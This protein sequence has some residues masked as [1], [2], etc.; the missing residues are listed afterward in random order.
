MRYCYPRP[1]SSSVSGPYPLVLHGGAS[2]ARAYCPPIASDRGPSPACAI[3]P[4]AR[5]PSTTSTVARS[6]QSSRIMSRLSPFVIFAFWQRNRSAPFRCLAGRWGDSLPIA[7]TRHVSKSCWYLMS[8]SFSR[9]LSGP[10][11]DVLECASRIDASVGMGRNSA[12]CV[13]AA[14]P[15]RL[16]SGL[17]RLLLRR[18][19]GGILLPISAYPHSLVL[20]PS[21]FLL[22]LTP[23][24]LLLSPSRRIRPSSSV[25]CDCAMSV[26]SVFGFRAS[27][28]SRPTNC[29][30]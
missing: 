21:H 13:S 4:I 24:L 7:P 25:F 16:S 27:A 18:P 26:A 9:V 19:F 12:R 3:S 6:D 22:S 28:A 1:S 14:S 29:F 11:A 10:G 2:Y 23:E 8:N 5:T 30:R 20:L 17:V 15:V